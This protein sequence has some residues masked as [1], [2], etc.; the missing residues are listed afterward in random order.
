MAWFNKYSKLNYNEDDS[1]SRYTSTKNAFFYVSGVDYRNWT[2]ELGKAPLNTIVFKPF[3]KAFEISLEVDTEDYTKDNV[4]GSPTQL[5][6]GQKLS[7]KVSLEL[8]SLSVQEAKINTGKVSIFNS[9]LTAP[10]QR[11]GKLLTAEQEVECYEGK[12]KC[13]VDS[14]WGH[15][16]QNVFYVSFSNIIQSGNYTNKK[17]IKTDEDIRRYGLRCEIHNLTTKVDTSV[18]YFEDEGYLLPKSYNITFAMIPLDRITDSK[19]M[20]KQQVHIRGFDYDGGYTG[21][22]KGTDIKTWPFGVK[23]DGE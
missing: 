1:T 11:M 15:A 6:T 9:M 14:D 7:Y 3:L 21:F 19:D 16:K 2:G 23:I 22:D 18:G 4:T 5:Y 17:L 8:P 12:K 20:Q 13:F 10:I